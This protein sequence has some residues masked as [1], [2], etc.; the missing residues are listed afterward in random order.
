VFSRRRFADLVVRLPKTRAALAYA[1][2]QHLGQQ[3]GAD[4]APFI[5]HPLEVGTLLYHAGA[6][7]NVVAAGILHDTIEKTSTGPDDLSERFG[8]R[9]ARLVLAVSEDPRI[10]DYEARKAALRRQVAAVGPQALMILAADKISKAR[11]LRLLPARPSR[12]LP[13]AGPGESRE[14]KLAHY[15]RCAEMLERLLTGSPLVGELRA[16]LEWA[17]PAH[18]GA[19]VLVGSV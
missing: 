2:E 11:E 1:Q 6:G 3:R 7:D 19:P 13:A 12:S 8:S 17:D 5:M 9:V 15:H 18:R 14:R 4:G 10:M 16:E